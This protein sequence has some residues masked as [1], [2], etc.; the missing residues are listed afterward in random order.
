LDPRIAIL[1]IPSLAVLGL[2]VVHSA[3]ALPRA[4]ALGFWGSV[5]GYGIIRGL[6]LSLVI[7]RGLGASFPYVI[8]NPLLPVFGVPLQELA[9]WGIVAY[10]GWW[11]GARVTRAVFA[12]VAWACLFLGAVSWVVEAAASAAGWWTWTVPVSHPFFIN[13]PFIGIV[14]WLFVGID[15]LLPFVALSAPGLKGSPARYSS[16]LAFPAHF[17]AHALKGSFGGV[18]VQHAAHWA[19]I[20]VILWLVL[21]SDAVDGP[22]RVV[23]PAYRWLPVAALAIVVLDAAVVELFIARRPELLVSFVPLLCVTAVSL[24]PE[25]SAAVSGILAWGRRRRWVAIATVAIV[26]AI[27]VIVHTAASRGQAE[28]TRRLDAALAARDRGDLD[29][30]KRELAALALDY[31]GS[32]VPSA[33]LGEIAYRTERLDEARQAFTRAVEIKPD[34]AKGFR[35]L[36][37]IDL[38]QGRRESAADAAARGLAVDAGDP[39]L[40]YLSARAQFVRGIAHSIDPRTPEAALTLASLAFEVGDTDS[41]AGFLQ[42]GLARWPGERRFFPAIVNLAVSLKNQPAALEYLALWRERFPE[43]AEARQMSRVLG[44]N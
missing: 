40:Q 5:L 21:R 44:I 10:L 36:A 3:R 20:A 24:R 9:G 29:G 2:L 17:T 23:G 34:Y 19:L 39:E 35:Y 37:V 26:A 42:S 18:P 43:D 8:K 31:P 6:A 30:A 32:H 1:T 14:D 22:F 28:L 33:L 38:R 16:L 13:V 27:T 25:T 15:F 11:L 12:Q 4:R 7:E 41:A